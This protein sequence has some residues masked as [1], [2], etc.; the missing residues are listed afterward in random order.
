M[1][2]PRCEGGGEGVSANSWSPETE[3]MDTIMLRLIEGILDHVGGP[4]SEGS[5]CSMAWR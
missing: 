3:V 5:E 4:G 2:E 1:I